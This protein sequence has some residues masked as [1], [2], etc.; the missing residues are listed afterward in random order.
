MKSKFAS[1][2]ESAKSTVALSVSAMLPKVKWYSASLILHT[3]W[4]CCIEMASRRY[5]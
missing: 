2:K 5:Y 1:V 4:L 3:L